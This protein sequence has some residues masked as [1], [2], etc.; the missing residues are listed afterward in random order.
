MKFSVRLK[1]F[2]F[3][4]IENLFDWQ[5]TSIC[6]SSGKFL[7]K[8]L[9]K[10][11][12]RFLLRRLFGENSNCNFICDGKK[13]FSRMNGIRKMNEKTSLTN[14]MK[15]FTAIDHSQFDGVWVWMRNRFDIMK[16]IT[17]NRFY[18][19]VLYQQS[20]KLKEKEETFFWVTSSFM[21]TVN[22]FIISEW[23]MKQKEWKKQIRNRL[24][25]SFIDQ[26][27]SSIVVIFEWL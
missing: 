22:R 3:L 23:K 20:I 18:L 10:T 17:T 6:L 14:Q 12:W 16:M 8:I 5:K 24:F 7:E 27:H 2:Y 25:L 4:Q 9:S 15:T 26:I 1:T 21:K 11:K 13:V 19:C